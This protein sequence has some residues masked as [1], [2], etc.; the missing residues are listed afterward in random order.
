MFRRYLIVSVF[1]IIAACV[2][3]LI[4]GVGVWVGMVVG[5]IEHFEIKWIGID[6]VTGQRTGGV[7][8]GWEV[9]GFEMTNLGF[10]VFLIWAG[11]ICIASSIAFIQI[12][13][14]KTKKR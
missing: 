11:S 7:K 6:P 4:C 12:H 9:F 2:G 8:T 10:C 14:I 5:V 3:V 1:W 13:L